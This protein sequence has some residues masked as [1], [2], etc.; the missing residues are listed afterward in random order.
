MAAATHV[1]HAMSLL[2]PIRD[3]FTTSAGLARERVRTVGV[4]RLLLAWLLQA[5][6]LFVVG[7]LVPGI[8]VTNLLAALSG[9]LV[10][11]LLNAL[12]RPVL[13]LLTLPLSVLSVG[14]ISLVINALM[15]VIAAPFVPGLEVTS[16]AAAFAAA[17]LITV[18][19]TLISVVLSSDQDDSFYAELSRRLARMNQPPIP[20]GRGLIVIQIDGLAAPILRNAIRVGLTP[21]MASWVRG[22]R[23]RFV[24]WEAS[25]SSQ[26]SASQGGILHGNNTDIPAFRWYEKE[27]GRLMV[28]NHP[29][30]AT[31]IEH[32]ISD[33]RGLLA[34]GGSSIGNLFSGDAARTLLTMSRMDPG[35]AADVDAFSL[36]FVDPA[37]FVRTIVLT[38]GE[39][40]KEWV[41]ARR[42]RALDLQPRIHRGGAFP[43]LRAVTNVVM[44]DLNVTFLV[45]AIGR[46]TPIMYVDFVDY[47]EVAHHAGP[48][49]LE[50]LR[51]LAGVDQVIATI[52]RATANAPR[53]YE[54]VVL[55]DHG[56]S[57][58]ATFL[59]RYGKTLEGLI[60]ELMSGEATALTINAEGE[61][62]GPVNALLTEIRQRPGV[63]GRVASSALRNKTVDGVVELGKPAVLTGPG[64]KTPAL[65]VCASGNLA[66][67]YF[68][69]ATERLAL[70]DIEALHPGLVERLVAHPG[71]GFVMV[72][73]QAVGTVIIGRAG[74]H[75]LADGHVE[76]ED[77]LAPF[78]AR[79]ADHLR[80]ADGFQHVGDL[81]VNSSY[82]E[83]LE[84]VAAFEE[85]VGSHGGFGGPQVRPFILAPADLPF[86]DLP[87]VGAPAV[88]R[89]LVRWADLLSVGPGSGAGDSPAVQPASMPEPRG[90]GV[91]AALIGLSSAIWTALGAL[92]L[93]GGIV[94][95]GA[96]Y[97]AVALVLLGFGAAGFAVAWGLWRRRGW[98]W[99]TALVL[100]GISVVQV[101]LT[102]AANGL[103]G[104]VRIG[105]VPVVVAFLAFF[106]LTRPH[107]AAAFGRRGSGGSR[108]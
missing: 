57:Q 84:E 17:I 77:P 27:R 50:S 102:V 107:V 97:L 73:T 19:T 1:F 70:E 54:I 25:P 61:G 41:E 51:S 32:R 40:V 26:T 71:I 60:L 92:A 52:E 21:R 105:L 81:L 94:V 49:R 20:G 80:R 91:L 63:A 64:G 2:R 35:H 31:E 108:R 83:E 96:E 12:V 45:N 65:V 99:L 103:E 82:D 74:V 101:L 68:T 62:W 106:Y 39:L 66:L 76:G 79:A 34:A 37:A 67:T 9:A 89:Q 13:I 98:A 47:D 16:F 56:Q 22:G 58:G 30:D 95:G 11:G 85:L 46:G 93:V 53:D 55:S 42:Q 69:G 24:E 78:G 90:I 7:W 43:V 5:I 59:Q 38:I 8:L 18:I 14:L 86:D 44:R 72:R 88:Y 4:R 15:L 36:Y 75:H 6:A 29:A 23:Y 33:G 104:I 10:I 48:E 100:E 87:I 3:T 28:S